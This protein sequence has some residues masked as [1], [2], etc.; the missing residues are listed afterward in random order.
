MGG[1]FVIEEETG[2]YTGRA[3]PHN[4]YYAGDF[5]GQ[6]VTVVVAWGAGSSGSSQAA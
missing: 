3:H 2:T 4:G 6:P 1:S 5:S